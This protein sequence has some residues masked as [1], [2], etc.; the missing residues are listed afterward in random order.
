VLLEVVGYKTAV[1]NADATLIELTITTFISTG[2]LKKIIMEIEYI[3]K[4]WKIIF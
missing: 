3:T 2:H 4:D 1:S